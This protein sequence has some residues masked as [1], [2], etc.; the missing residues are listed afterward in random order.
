MFPSLWF[1]VLFPGTCAA[2]CFSPVLQE[3]RT[4]VCRYVKQLFCCCQKQQEASNDGA[5]DIIITGEKSIIWDL[6][7]IFPSVESLDGGIWGEGLRKQPIRSQRL[8][9]SRRL[10][11]GKYWECGNKRQQQQ[12]AAEQQLWDL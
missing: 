11:G 2:L 5:Y 4:H 10:G 7:H 3:A 8:S 1:V 6:Y 9:E 12:Q